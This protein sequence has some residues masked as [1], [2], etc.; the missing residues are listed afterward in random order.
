MVRPGHELRIPSQQEQGTRPPDGIGEAEIEAECRCVEQPESER[1][2]T[3]GQRRDEADSCYGRAPV[4]L[5]AAYDELIA[6]GDEQ[7]DESDRYG[8]FR[9]ASSPG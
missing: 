9:V 4:W 1:A 5:A 3:E 7:A 8:S 6:R 2:V